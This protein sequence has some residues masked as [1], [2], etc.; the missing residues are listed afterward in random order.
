[1][2]SD[3]LGTSGPTAATSSASVDL[4]RYAWISIYF[5][6]DASSLTFSVVSESPPLDISDVLSNELA[7]AIDWNERSRGNAD[8][9]PVKVETAR[10]SDKTEVEQTSGRSEVRQES[11]DEARAKEI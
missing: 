3:G 8:F 10:D 5:I 1:M 11:D 7:P 6:D 9:T 4:N 2:P